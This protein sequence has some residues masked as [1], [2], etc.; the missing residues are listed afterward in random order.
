MR[1]SSSGERFIDLFTPRTLPIFLMFFFW[2]FGTGG[3]WLVRPLFA[4]ELSGSLLLVGLV[5]AVSAAPRSFTGP[6]TGYL[7]DRFGR[8]W[9]VILGAVIHI[10]ALIGQFNSTA[11]L[12]YFLME[13]LA[14]LG[15]GAWMTSSNALM[16]DYT[17]LATRGRAV[18]LR[19]TSSR[20]GTLMG[21]LV[22][23]LVAVV[24][25]LRDVFLFIAACKVAVIIVTLLWVRDSRSAPRP[26]PDPARHGGGIVRRLNLAMFRSRAFLVLIVATFS[27]NLVTG[28]TG[29][30]RT[31]FP[32][33]GANAAGLDEARVGT[34]IMFSGIL[35]LGAA[36]PAGIAN[37][38]IGRKRTLVFA[39]LATSLAV[40][41]MSGLSDFES[42]LLAVLAFGLAEAFATG[43][44]QVYAMDLAPHDR[45]GAFLGVWSL[46]MIAGQVFGPIVI[47]SVAD[48]AGFQ[49][50][51]IIVSGFLIA[52]G[53]VVAIFGVET[54]RPRQ[55]SETHPP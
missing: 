47:G 46:S 32:V 55:Q 31:F 39:L 15:I 16:A 37:D 36:I 40:W 11:Y 8:K 21:P 1:A 19:Q 10:V 54:R 51:F 7:T 30:F 9:F 27:V 41:M 20:A 43:T 18:A 53:V 29:V 13:L 50:A 6:L 52:A 4:Y 12:Q 34:L 24:G 49:T 48:S 17:Q 35:A 33:Q 44:N 23:G 14:G 28:G 26:A 45:R 25:D 22:A 3:L 42:A 5:S 38:R 2:G